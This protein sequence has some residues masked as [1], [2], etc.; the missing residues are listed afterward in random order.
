MKFN[1]SSFGRCFR[2]RNV[3]QIG[4]GG[5]RQLDLVAG[6]GGRRLLDL[7]AGAGGRRLL[8]L[9]AGAGG[10]RQLDLVAGAGGRRLL[11]LVAGAGGRRLLDLVAGAGGRRLLD[12]V[13]GGVQVFIFQKMPR[14]NAPFLEQ[15]PTRKTDFSARVAL[16]LPCPSANRQ[17][18]KSD[19][20]VSVTMQ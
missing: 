16:P 13:A 7:V 18:K 17:S 8:D 4:A 20:S 1:F 14:E 11:D 9:V 10:R 6:A 15:S 19:D 2:S 5:R 12:L 3:L